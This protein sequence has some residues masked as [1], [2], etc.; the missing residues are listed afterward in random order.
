MKWRKRVKDRVVMLFV[1]FGLLITMIPMV[2]AETPDLI[3]TGTGV[4]TDVEIGSGDWSKY[5][6]KEIV[7][8]GN[9]S[10]NFHKITKVRGYDLFELVGEENL[11][12]GQDWEMTFICADGFTFKKTVSEL[13]GTY[14]YTDFTESSKAQAPAMIARY[15]AVLGDYPKDSFAPPVTWT[16]RQLGD[17]DIDPDFPKLVFGQTDIDDMNLSKW[18]KKVIKIVIGDERTTGVEESSSYK[19]IS[20][21][22]A[23]Y[24]IDAISGATF[25][26]EGPAVEGYRALSLRQL[27]EDSK[28]EERVEYYEKFGTKTVLNTYEGI[29]AKYLLDNYVKLKSNAGNITFKNKSRQT[30]VT[31][32][33]TEAHKYTVAYGI[34]QVPYV[35]LDS[36]VGYRQDKYNDNGCFKLIYSQDKENAVEFSN[37][38]YIYVE[39]KD[40]KNIFE[41]TYAPY[42][43]PQYTDYE[44][45]I[46]GSAIDGVSR[47]KVSEIEKMEDIKFTGEYSLSNSEYFWYYN[48]YKGVKLWDLLLKAGLNPKISDDTSLRFIAAD[49]YNFA[50][51]TVGEIRD[52]SLYGYYEKDSLDLGDGKFDGTKV[53]PLETGM[54]PLVAFGF[55]GYPY[56]IRPTDDGFNAGLGNDGGPLRVIFGKTDYNDTNGSNQVQFIKEIIIGDGEP[57]EVGKTGDQTTG[58]DTAT[59]VDSLTTWNHNRDVY[60]EYLDLPVLRIT[61]SQVKQPMTFTLRQIESML[62]YTLR[63]TYTGDGIRELEGVELWRVIS[64]FIG[65]KDDVDQPTVRVFSGA[66]YNQILRNI[67][68]LKN[69]VVNSS[70]KNKK[71]IMAYAAD[72]YPLVPNEASNGYVNN[73]AYGPLRLVIEESKSMWVKWLD[74]VVVG[75]GDYEEPRIEDVKELDLPELPEPGSIKKSAENWIIH[76]NDTGFEMAEA[77]VRIM[78]YDSSGTLWI[79]TNSGGLSSRTKDGKWSIITEL[80]TTN[81]GKVKV[82]TTYAIVQRENG[83]LWLSLGGPTDPRGILIKNG[84]VWKLI[85]QENSSLPANFVQE[86]ELDG[87]G[88]L[89]I[90]TEKGIVHVDKDGQWKVY[91][92][93]EGLLPYSV[94]ALEPDNDGGVWIGYYP[95]GGTEDNPLFYGGY[96]Y[97][98]S[99]GIVTTY[100]GFDPENFNVNWV[101]SISLDI[102]GGVWIVRSGNAPGFGQGEVDYIKDGIKKTYK[103]AELFKDLDPDNDIRLIQASPEDKDILYIATVTGGLIRLNIETDKFESYLFENSFPTK[104][105]N[106]VYFIDIQKDMVMMGTN[107]GAAILKALPEFPDCA[108]HWAGNAISKMAE[109][110]Y[111]KGDN[112]EF[113]PDDNITRAEFVALLTRVLG[114]SGSNSSSAF[115]DIPD[116]VW[117]KEAVIAAAEAGLVNGYDDGTFRPSS[118]ITRT[119]IASILGRVLNQEITPTQVEDAISQFS[120]QIASWAKDSVAISVRSGIIQGFPDGSFGGGS[121]AT[122]AQTAIMLSRLLGHE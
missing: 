42:D 74:C 122:R 34:N 64:E 80:E 112:G 115:T 19:H 121:S 111:I 120:D 27:E 55:N 18:G 20:Y 118:R 68:Q 110:G 71:I 75:S 17:G 108:G 1:I 81:A 63:D 99:E 104:Q 77:S 31:V 8:S 72:G 45:L 85:N 10:L 113:R 58:E 15:S 101:R 11:L 56:V 51:L 36:D 89:Y 92:V 37:V 73:N 13:R 69:G 78:E 48:N 21:P 54:P 93:K 116:S 52:Y 83:E 39:E 40:A 41:H 105:W 30:I 3:I 60:K 91:T 107:G 100:E 29:N 25:T 61:G 96:Q 50:P 7:L 16:D 23:P 14:T 67:D 114:L 94:D 76:R 102:D 32:P 59:K 97:L 117:Y 70:G 62:D 5:E 24:N 103:A 47:F 22:G 79:G 95:G 28:G 98:S 4:K 90:G 2:T 84:D 38:A 119:E 43:A 87:K 12:S 66:N 86:L 106:N 49:S 26:I 9:N 82:D 88:G 6:I 44:I 46:H 57:I 33:V 53:E 109:M 35:Y 65:L